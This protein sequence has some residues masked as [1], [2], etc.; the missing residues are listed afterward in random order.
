[1]GSRR[2]STRTRLLSVTLGSFG[3]LIALRACAVEQPPTPDPSAVVITPQD[4]VLAEALRETNVWRAGLGLPAL[5][6]DTRAAEAA[7]HH[8]ED[9]AAQDSLSHHGSDGSNP[10]TRMR[11]AGYPT[12]WWAENAAAG[13]PT[14]KDVVWGWMNSP[15]HAANVLNPQATDVG[16]AVAYSAD[17]TPYWTMD[18]ASGG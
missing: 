18:L 8:S 6:W 14:A 15:A 12:V 9:L 13:Y 11:D 4:P 10:K 5:T 3:S 17:G 1:M 2:V 16:I 7:R